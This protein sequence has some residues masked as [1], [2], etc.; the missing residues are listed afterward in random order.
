MMM[1]TVVMM[2]ILSYEEEPC[3]SFQTL[4]EWYGNVLHL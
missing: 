1:M 3:Q 2:V 4:L